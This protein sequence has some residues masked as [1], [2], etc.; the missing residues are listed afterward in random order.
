MS[1]R[2][3]VVIPPLRLGKHLQILSP[4]QIFFGVGTTKDFFT[5]QGFRQNVSDGKVDHLICSQQSL[6]WQ[7]GSKML[8]HA[9]IK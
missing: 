1:E 7:I 4:G 9:N 8:A 6:L 3:N 5:P 2:Q